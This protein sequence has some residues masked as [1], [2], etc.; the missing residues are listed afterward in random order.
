MTKEL[1]GGLEMVAKAAQRKQQ[2]DKTKK[3]AA[4]DDDHKK[5]DD[6]DDEEIQWD[7]ILGNCSRLYPELFP[8]I[9]PLAGGR[10]LTQGG[11]AA[12]AAVNEAEFAEQANKVNNYKNCKEKR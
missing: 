10:G 2:H 4:K 9:S 12:V 7:T 6:D 8:P 11:E 5:A 1:T 3:K